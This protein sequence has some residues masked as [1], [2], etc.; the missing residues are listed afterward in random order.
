MIEK[1]VNIRL[2][3]KKGKSKDV[4]RY[5]FKEYMKLYDEKDKDTIDKIMHRELFYDYLRYMAKS[6]DGDGK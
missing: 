6:G 4:V 5:K 1:L 3:M 2:A